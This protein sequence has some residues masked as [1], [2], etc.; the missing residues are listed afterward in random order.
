M[1]ISMHAM[2]HGVFKRALTQPLHVRG[3]EVRHFLISRCVLVRERGWPPRSARPL[4][5]AS[6]DSPEPADTPAASGWGS[7]A[8]SGS[9]AGFQ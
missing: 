9:V 2:S 5:Q 6:C 1:T 8:C 7:G 4:P 3:G